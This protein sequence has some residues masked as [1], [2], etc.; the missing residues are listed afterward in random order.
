MDFVS[1]WIVGPNK[2]SIPVIN[3]MDEGSR[4]ALWATAHHNIS[5]KTLVE[6]LDKILDWRG[7][8]QYIRCN[9]GPGFI[10][11]RLRVWSKKHQVKIKFSQPGKPPQNGLIERLNKTLRVECLNLNWFTSLPQLN[12]DLQKWWSDYNSCRPHDN[13]ENITHDRYEIKNQNFYYLA[14]G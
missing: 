14:V 5:A 11:H 9:N 3:I 1:D 6:V 13:I 8:P 7:A 10:S 12:E 2:K 4:K